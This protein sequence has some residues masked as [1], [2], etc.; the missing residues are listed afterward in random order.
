MRKSS[1]SK[2]SK[3]SSISCGVSGP[4][5]A[6]RL[7]NFLCQRAT[8]RR[9]V[10]DA[11]R[12]RPRLGGDLVV[13]HDARDEPLV[14]RLGGVEHAALE[15]D[16]ER[17]A[18]ADQPHQRR[19][20]RVRHH[21]AEVLDRRAEAARL[22]ADAEVGQRG[23]LE[24]AAD[25]DAVDLRDDRRRAAGELLGGGVHHLAVLDRLR[26]A[27][28]LRLELADVVAGRERL[29]SRAAHD[30]AADARVLR[31]VPYRVAELAPH[32]AGEGVQLVRA[33]QH[34]G[35]DGAV[36]FDEDRR[37]GQRA[38][39]VMRRRSSNRATCARRPRSPARTASPVRGS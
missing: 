25:A 16:L 4:P 11:L 24:P 6:R 7:A 2:Q 17:D 36:A 14:L 33:V 3:H 5:S 1:V 39:L 8:Q 38:A 19:H 34:D 13:R 9:A 20:L 10:R 32:R 12:G 27:G 15:Q 28:A 21:E 23:D 35:G 37:V 30:D 18:L 31:Q 26:L 22:P 29:L